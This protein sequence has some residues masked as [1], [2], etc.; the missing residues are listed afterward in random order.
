MPP[1]V[2]LSRI[3]LSFFA[4]LRKGQMGTLKQAIGRK[5]LLSSWDSGEL[6]QPKMRRS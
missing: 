5:G 3:E 4:G 1:E 6:L 2:R